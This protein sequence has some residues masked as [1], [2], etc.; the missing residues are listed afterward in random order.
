MGNNVCFSSEQ[1]SV[2]VAAVDSSHPMESLLP[3][4]LK[5]AIALMRSLRDH[6]GWVAAADLSILAC[7]AIARPGNV[8]NIV[9]TRTVM[10]ALIKGGAPIESVRGKGY[11]WQCSTRPQRTRR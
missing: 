9:H 10:S 1:V 5:Y 4:T 8:P 2:M 3:E 7:T 11:C 6:G